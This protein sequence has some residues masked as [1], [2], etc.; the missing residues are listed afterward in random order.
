MAKRG[1]KPAAGER[2][3][4]RVEV[5]FTLDEL[6]AIQAL[7]R[8]NGSSVADMLRL[9]ALDIANQMGECPPTVLRH[10]ILAILT[11]SNSAPVP[12]S[13]QDRGAVVVPPKVRE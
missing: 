2:A 1:R 4:R 9:A 10:R 13:T 5:T 11:G 7:A 12:L 6:R 8:T 3:T